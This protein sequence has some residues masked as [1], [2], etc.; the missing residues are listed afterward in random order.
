VDELA[1]WEIDAAGTVTKSTVALAL[2]VRFFA[3]A[4]ASG[5]DGVLHVV[6]QMV[7]TAPGSITRLM[8]SNNRGGSFGPLAQVLSDARGG[9]V[10]L[11]VDDNN[12]VYCVARSTSDTRVRFSLDGGELFNNLISFGA[13]D[14]QA[15]SARPNGIDIF[16]VVE[17]EN[18]L[19]LWRLTGTGLS[20]RVDVPTPGWRAAD[21]EYFNGDHFAVTSGPLQ[22]TR[23]GGVEPAGLGDVNLSGAVDAADI[24]ALRNHLDGMRNL[25]AAGLLFAD[26]DGDLQITD[27]DVSAIASL[28]IGSGR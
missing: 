11:H 6:V 26:V 19:G 2:N 17:F 14:L 4:I 15:V 5:P 25:N 23:T 16:E 13:T 18:L 8:Y 27:D 22:F 1:V 7:S 10:A 24:V 28:V 12:T 20:P 21:I 9:D 3:G